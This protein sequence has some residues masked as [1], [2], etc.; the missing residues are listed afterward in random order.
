[1]IG[2]GGFASVTAVVTQRTISLAPWGDP[3]ITMASPVCSGSAKGVSVNSSF[4]QT[5]FSVTKTGCSTGID[6]GAQTA[7]SSST[8]SA[9]ACVTMLQICANIADLVH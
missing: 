7:T 8:S 9:R 1:M 6:P 3:S 5:G 2:T 4:T